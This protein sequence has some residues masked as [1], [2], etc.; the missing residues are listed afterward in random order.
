[1]HT[2][3]RS[4]G[5][6][7]A[8]LETVAVGF[9]ALAAVHRV[10]APRPHPAQLPAHQ[11]PPP[12]GPFITPEHDQKALP[13]PQLPRL[14]ALWSPPPSPTTPPIPIDLPHII[15]LPPPNPTLDPHPSPTTPVP[16]ALPAP[17]DTNVIRG[18]IRGAIDCADDV[19]I[20]QTARV[21]ANITAASITVAG[22]LEGELT[23]R[24]RVEIRGTGRVIGTLH[25][26]TLVIRDG[27]F[28]QGDIQLPAPEP[29]APAGARLRRLLVLSTAIR[30][31]PAA[32][33]VALTL[34]PDTRPLQSPLAPS[35]TAAS[36]ASQPD[37]IPTPE[38]A[39]GAD[40]PVAPPVDRVPD[41][42]APA[43]GNA[44]AAIPTYPFYASVTGTE[45]D[46]LVVRAGPGGDYRP[47]GAFLEESPLQVIDGPTTRKDKSDWYRVVALGGPSLAG[48]S[49]TSFLAP[50]PP[51]ESAPTESHVAPP[52]RPTPT[53]T[54]PPARS[55]PRPTSVRNTQV[56]GQ[57]RSFTA[58]LTAYSY[59]LPIGGAHGS[60]TKSG[61]PVRWGIVAIDPAVIPLGSRLRIAGFDTVFLA[62]D[63]G[64]GVRGYH[65]DIFFDS[66]AAAI[67]FG[68]QYR[69]VTVLA[70]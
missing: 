39:A 37:T 67:Q 51:E 23:S 40:A 62:A 69:S 43:D 11:E 22:N 29:S 8:A 25:T 12:Q 45:D 38:P 68:V 28:V 30:L 13:T 15:T 10:L 32:L 58:K 31:A 20:E 42:E 1:M 56:P 63:T 18:T 33:L 3:S 17:A 52:P 59:Q 2:P 4:T 5:V 35:H 44:N 65:V 41:R 24:G 55:N 21:S 46:G 53:R 14:P 9:G 47:L 66:H 16:A 49:T 34:I 26:D 64:G 60:I 19:L 36:F 70:S 50:V 7:H 6:H 48:W 61:I 54:T 27:G 57:G